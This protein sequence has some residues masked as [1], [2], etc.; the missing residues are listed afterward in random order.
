M[1]HTETFVWGDDFMTGVT[2]VDEQHHGLVALFNDLSDALI[3]GH[4]LDAGQAYLVFQRLLNYAE[5]HFREE[6]QLMRTGGLDPRHIDSHKELH[7]AFVD[8][9]RGLWSTKDTMSHPAEVFL[10]FLT[11]WLGLHIL[12]VDQSMAR[13]MA[14]IRSGEDA[15]L[16]YVA[17]TH[18]KDHRTEAM[19]KAM[20]AIYKVLSKLNLELS[21]ANLQ[22]EQRVRERTFELEQTN[23][24]LVQAN[25][26]LEVYSHTDGL[27]NIANRKYF[28]QRLQEEWLR[29]IRSKQPVGLLM[30]DVDHFKR[31][32]DTYGHQAGDA[33]LR[34]VAKAAAG[35][36][37]RSTD[38]LARYGGEELVVVLPD[39]H[40]EGT[41]QVAQDICAAVAKLKIP[42]AGSDTAPYVT[43]SLGVAS[44]NPPRVSSADRLVAAADQALYQAKKQGRNQVCRD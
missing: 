35:A 16:A 2:P 34:A 9:L 38:L 32:N 43:V 28:D 3:T 10:S 5:H 27:L 26:K 30:I 7:H 14:R 1:T 6:E 15:A 44:M 19:I 17:E 21:S 11:S 41:Y 25:H 23:Q 12:G 42:H 31:Y 22:L 29:A 8:Q 20:G 18:P 24:A 33:C 39:T 40:V 4:D 36:L 13:Q 37:A